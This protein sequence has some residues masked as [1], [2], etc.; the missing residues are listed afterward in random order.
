MFPA[1]EI[2]YI[3]KSTHHAIGT[4]GYFRCLFV[5]KIIGILTGL[6]CQFFFL[7]TETI[8]E[9]AH[10]K[11]RFECK[12]FILPYTGNCV[13]V[14]TDAA[15]GIGLPVCSVKFVLP[16]AAAEDSRFPRVYHTN[17]D[18]SQLCVT[19]A[20]YDRSAHCK[21]GIFVP[22]FGY[23]GNDSATFS[24]IGENIGTESTFLGDGRIPC[25]FL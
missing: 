9:P 11:A 8:P 5:H 6:F 22:F 25:A 23:A 4:G 18:T 3:R 12:G 17:A 19:T 7:L 13:T 16:E 14:D 2:H 10:D 1:D 24:Y 20:R 15:V 21:S